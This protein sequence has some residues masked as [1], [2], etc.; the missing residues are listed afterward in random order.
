[1][2]KRP[3]SDGGFVF[4]SLKNDKARLLAPVLF[5]MELLAAR[6]RE[7]SLQRLRAGEAWQGWQDEAER[8]VSPVFTNE[9]GAH[10][11]P[12]TVY[13]HFKKLAVQIGAPH[14]RVH[15]LRHP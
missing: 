10:L 2:Q 14:A 11:H 8:E 5:V 15:D 12:Q 13:N 1:L 4:A 3:L 6:R 9:F 7:E